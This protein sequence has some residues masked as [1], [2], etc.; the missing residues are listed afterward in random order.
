MKAPAAVRGTSWFDQEFGSN[1][2]AREYAGWDWFALHLSDGR[3]LMVY[4]LRRKNGTIERESSGTLVE[5]DGASRHLRFVDIETTILS[6]W[7]SN[8][9]PGRYPAAWRIRVSGAAIDVTVTPLVAG[10]E[11]ITKAST[12]ITYWEGAI[13]GKGT[14]QGK[15]VAVEGYA[16]L[17]GY[18]GALGGIF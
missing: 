6:H 2:M 16:E 11:L 4:Y 17:T 9:S 13:A 12:A 5:R 1:Q 8:E 3:D 10:Q 15:E 7:K 18:A 14:S